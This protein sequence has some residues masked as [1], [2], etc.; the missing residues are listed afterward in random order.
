MRR[1]V[2]FCFGRK[3]YFDIELE[4]CITTLERFDFLMENYRMRELEFDAVMLI[5]T[6]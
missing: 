3:M 2:I 5:G 6:L 4:K 1:V